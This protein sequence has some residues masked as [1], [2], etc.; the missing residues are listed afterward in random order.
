MRGTKI[1]YDWVSRFVED[2][3]LNLRRERGPKPDDDPS[4][5]VSEKQKGGITADE[6]RARTLAGRDV[7]QHYHMPET[8]GVALP[9][10]PLKPLSVVPDPGLFLGR[11]VDLQRLRAFLDDDRQGLFILAGLGGMGK[12]AL[13][14]QAV[15]SFV[16]DLSLVFWHPF[17]EKETL[18]LDTLFLKLRTFFQ[19]HGD[20][21]L[22]GVLENPEATAEDK[23][24]AV[25]NALSKRKYY[26][27][28][29][30]LH[31]L[32]DR[33]HEVEHPGLRQLFGRFVEG[34]YPSRIVVVSRI[35]PVFEKQLIGVEAEAEVTGLPEEVSYELMKALD[36]PSKSPELLQKVYRV[37]E[38]HP[39]AIRLLSGLQ[40][41]R[42]LKGLLED[43][44][45][46]GKQFQDRLL[47]EVIQDVEETERAF[48]LVAIT[49]REALR[50]EVFQYHLAEER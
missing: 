29:D 8:E 27:I 13:T 25:V 2:F 41:K 10:T 49:H 48:L 4:K 12:T 3:F 43:I 32:L 44:S 45:G 17:S 34:G 33:S 47:E 50:E 46:W 16:A 30:D 42:S 18:S 21:S 20:P 22:S 36:Y 6:V 23:V 39:E 7:I 19:G 5:V 15:R 37:T 35:R 9:Q 14:A 40:K 11:E 38:G 28:F 31:L 1:H 26:L 24:N